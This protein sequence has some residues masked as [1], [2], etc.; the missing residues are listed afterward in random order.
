[1][2]NPLS[3][4]TLTTMPN[5][6]GAGTDNLTSLP[7]ATALGQGVLDFSAAPVYD[8][9]IAPMKVKSGST[10][11]SASGL[12]TG[13]II[14]SE[15]NTVWTDGISPTS[16]SDQ[17]AKIATAMVAF[18]IAVVANATTYQTPEV[19]IFAI[20]GFVPRYAALVVYNQ[21][22]HALDTTST[23]FYEK[24]SITSYV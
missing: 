22:G 10:G 16:A 2:T 5:G 6:P 11:T 9:V 23:N 21:S 20:L 18:Q 19:S 3:Y 8:C 17:S 15:D 7:S 24:Y 4:G 13:Y 14:T 1:M 12:L